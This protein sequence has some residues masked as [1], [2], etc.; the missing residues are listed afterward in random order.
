MEF[1]EGSRK[2]FELFCRRALTFFEEIGIHVED[3]QFSSEKERSGI[4]KVLRV[5]RRGFLDG[6]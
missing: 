6:L 1:L 3:V 4:E 2:V 5:F